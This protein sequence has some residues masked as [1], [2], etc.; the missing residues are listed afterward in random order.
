MLLSLFRTNQLFTAI[1][2]LPYIAALHLA[3]VWIDDNW[4]PAI[5]GVLT[6][7]F[8]DAFGYKTTFTQVTA[9]ALLFIQAVLVVIIDFRHKLSSEPTLFAGVFLAL[10]S[11][12]SVPFLHLSSYYFSNIFLLIAIDQLLVTYRKANVSGHLLN[13]GFYIGVAA[14]FSPTYLVYILLAFVGLNILRGFNFNERL[15]VLIGVLIVFILAGTLYFWYGQLD[16]FWQIQFIDSF[17][18]WDYRA[19]NA[20]TPI[21]LGLLF[22][23]VLIMIFL[24]VQI[25]ARKTMEVQKKIDIFYWAMLISV[26]AVLFQSDVQENS[27]LVV[28]PFLGLFLGIQ[29]GNLRSNISELLHLLFLVVVLLLQYRPFL[30]P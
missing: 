15:T 3:P 17:S 8:F 29:W 14:L 2:L 5:H 21:H 28:T 6:D 22:L 23:L 13:V 4:E 24:R 9:G 19:G 30:L 20:F 11:S 16:A 1:F 27:F 25:V 10:V 26:L 18:L 7:L 12:V